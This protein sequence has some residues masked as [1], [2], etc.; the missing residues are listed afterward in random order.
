MKVLSGSTNPALAQAIASKLNLELVETEIGTFKNGEKRV[1]IKG[2][3][4]GDNVILVQDFADPSKQPIMEFLL[5][6]DALERLGARHVN[7][8]MPWMGYSLQDKVFRDGEPISAKVVANL[9]SNAFVKRVFVLDLHNSS[10]PGFF[11]IPT[12][13][14]SALELFREYAQS[15][16]DHDQIVVVSP[17]FGGI[18]R[19]RVLADSLGVEL[20]NI[21]KHRNLETGEV[22]PVE[23]HGGEVA[24][25]IVLVFDDCINGGSTVVETARFLKEKG[26]AQ[27][28]FMV[29]H[30]PLVK[31]VAGTLQESAADS[32]VVTNS[33]TQEVLPSKFKVLDVSDVF[34]EALRNWL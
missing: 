34:V 22:T 15:T 16:F 18:K 26:A 7:L 31:G 20:V 9:I 10:T 33:I 1:W 6:A 14:L 24:G 21:D 4:K 19:A 32:I 13:H 28:H 12:H 23:L 11:S 25:K 5:L 3:V 30:G 2:Q 29:T 27:V 17:D 8:V